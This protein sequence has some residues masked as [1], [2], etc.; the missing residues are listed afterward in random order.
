MHHRQGSSR[1][2]QV[3]GSGGCSLDCFLS[4]ESFGGPCFSADGM[5]RAGPAFKQIL[6]I[7]NMHFVHVSLVSDKKRPGSRPGQSN[8]EVEDSGKPLLSTIHLCACLLRIK[9]HVLKTCANPLCNS[10]IASGLTGLCSFLPHLFAV[11]NH[12]LGDEI[13]K[14]RN[15]ARLSEFLGKCQVDRDLV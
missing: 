12:F 3:A 13:A 5:P 15:S 14:G 7:K 11:C 6:C 2:F 10:H 9:R 8:R 1:G 4:A